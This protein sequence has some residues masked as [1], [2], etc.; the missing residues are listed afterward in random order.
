[1]LS[2]EPWRAGVGGLSGLGRQIVFTD[3]LGGE[4]D[5]FGVISA[6]GPGEKVSFEVKASR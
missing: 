4:G 6:R 1:M 2:D 5:S 3:L